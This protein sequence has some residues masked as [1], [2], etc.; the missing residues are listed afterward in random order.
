M[1]KYLNRSIYTFFF[2]FKS[3]L[4]THAVP[5]RYSLASVFSSCNDIVIPHNILLFMKVHFVSASLYFITELQ[6][7][8]HLNNCHLVHHNLI[9]MFFKQGQKVA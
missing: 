4:F 2:G 6:S 9:L 3:C 5:L 1:I 7:E 8:L